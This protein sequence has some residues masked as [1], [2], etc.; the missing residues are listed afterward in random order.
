[1]MEILI[2][3]D[4]RRTFPNHFNESSMFTGGRQ[5]NKLKNEFRQHFRNISRIM[6]CVGCEKCKLWGKLQVNYDKAIL[7]D[8]FFLSPNTK[9]NV[10]KY[11][12][13]NF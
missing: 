5:A 8:N 10:K 3:L 6:D 7:L 4:A 13:F 9:I 11:K 2:V 1:M 12:D